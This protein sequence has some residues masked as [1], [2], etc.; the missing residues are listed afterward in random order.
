MLRAACFPVLLGS[1][2]SCSEQQ[3]I[4]AVVTSPSGESVAIVSHVS[5]WLSLH[6]QV[7]VR[8]RGVWFKD[9]D[10]LAF[11]LAG[12]HELRLTWRNDSSLIIFRPEPRAYE[13]FRSADVL[14]VHVEVSPR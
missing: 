8:K 3:Q 6:T 14:G 12:A 13:Q 11:S 9:G 5:G 4:R 10:G 1:L 7:H 2:I